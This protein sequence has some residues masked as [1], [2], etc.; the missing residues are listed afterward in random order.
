MQLPSTLLRGAVRLLAALI[1]VSLAGPAAA[2]H[3]RDG[4]T[5]FS[6]VHF[7]GRSETFNG[8]IRGLRGTII[9]NDRASSIA[10][11]GGCLVTLYRDARFRGPSVTVRHDIADLRATRVGN[12]QVSSLTVDCYGEGR[13]DDRYDDGRHGDDHHG[14]G[15]HGDGHHGD[16]HH[17]DGH[18]GDGWRQGGV[19]VFANARF[20]GRRE[21]FSYDDPDLRDNRIRQDTIS[22]IRVAPGCRAVLFA[23]VGFRGAVTVV[24]GDD[25]N[26]RYSEVGNDR[27]SSIQVDCRRY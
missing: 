6:D 13:G 23:D 20:R 21:S 4:V 22:S 24:S 1:L 14:D 7:A 26:L 9:G 27:V 12:D 10:V 18:H 11:P 19:T 5:L 8:D 2:G 25:P 16:G 3:D 15:H 17:G